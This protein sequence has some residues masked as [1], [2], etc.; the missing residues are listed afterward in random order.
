MVHVVIA[1]AP[2]DEALAEALAKPLEAAGYRVS[3]RGTV[4]VGESF[5]E[6]ASKA[7]SDGG[8]V[9][10]CATV[11]AIGTG[12]AHRLVHAAQVQ[13]SRKRIFPVRMEQ[14]AY[15][16]Q[17]AA[18]MAVAEYWRDA[19]GGIHSL[20]QALGKHYPLELEGAPPPAPESSRLFLDRITSL[21]TFDAEALE[22]F[23]A[24]LRD[25]VNRDFSADLHPQEFLRRAG[26][27]RGSH[28]T[29]TGVLLFGR[30]P[31]AVVPWAVSRC[32][33]YQGVS[34]T[35]D[36]ESVEIRGTVPEQIAALHR[37]IASRVRTR[38]RI[39]PDSPKAE[40][41]Y[42]YPMKTVREIIANALVHRDYEDQRR[43]VHVRLFTDQIEILSPGAWIGRDLPGNGNPV[44]LRDLVSESI[45]RNL[46]LAN[47]IS[48]AR[49]VEG[50]GSGLPTAIEECLEIS[51]PVP[52]VSKADGYVKVTILP[53]SDWGEPDL[54]RQTPASLHQ[55]PP[56]PA[57]FTGRNEELRE[58]RDKL[59][60]GETN[61]VA[62]QGLA[63][64]GKT[65]LAL[66]LAEELAPSFPDGQI[67]FNLRGLSS[68]PLPPSEAMAHVVR[69]FH[70]EA[71]L[72]SSDV[73][74]EALYRSVLH[75]RRTLLVFDDAGNAEQVE[76]L[77][78]PPGNV[79]LVTSR[80]QSSLM[81]TASEVLSVLPRMASR[82]ILLKLAPRIGD[83]AEE[84]AR[85]CGDLPLALNLAGSTLA[86]RPDLSVQE[87]IHRLSNLVQGE[88]FFKTPIKTSIET[89]IRLSEDLLKPELRSLWHRL[90]VFPAG[91]DRKAASAVWDLDSASAD[92]TLGEL[93][94]ASLI[95]GEEGR[96]HLHNLLRSFT[97]SRLERIERDTAEH[98]H[99]K[100][101]LEVLR[102][103][104][105]LYKQGGDALLQGL[106]L[107]DREWDNIQ[108]GHSWAVAH[109]DQDEEA[110]RWCSEYPQAGAYCLDL[111]RHPRERI[112][113]LESA[114]KAAL[115]L[116]DRSAEA[117]LSGSLGNAYMNLGE[118]R[119]ATDLYE[120]WSR[121]ARETGDPF[122]EGQ[123]LGNLGSAYLNLGDPLRAVELFE[124][125]LETTHKVGDLQG[126]GIALGNLASAYVT[127]GDLDRAVKLYDRRLE[128]A[129]KTGDLRGEGVTL[130][131]LANAYA[132]AGNL[133]SAGAFHRRSLALA[134]E[135]GDLRGQGI[136]LGNLGSVYR[137]LEEAE[138]AIE[139]LQQ[140]LEI[141]E[142]VGDRQGETAIS[143]ELGRVY[144]QE[145]RIE[146]AIPL[147]QARVDY[148]REV[149]HP[150]AE[151]H[152]EI[153]Q[154]IQLKAR[155]S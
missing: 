109:A 70:P 24:D 29:N 43:F 15:L 91:F 39:R 128:I 21:S 104:S 95:Y 154:R 1:H 77:R 102:T 125:W 59:T 122:G 124:R 129:R 92:E 62:L 152:A 78:P 155:T 51:A 121:I 18:D 17:I 114:L 81:G 41:T 74:L 50:E 107:F 23:R 44:S 82:E 64:V 61:V 42:E 79:V 37:A 4:L 73:E 76:S 131:N 112:D 9:V 69:S 150:D 97:S 119:Q 16:D 8:P 138:Q 20:L 141:L 133:E 118:I 48:W 34:K 19:S 60:S 134:R 148:E 12:W 146:Q 90:S 103:T 72:P 110:A 130:G 88:T 33:S 137:A 120:R 30:D 80:N 75:G 49:L 38:E 28:L 115:R 108:A 54:S 144:E 25:G 151:P 5:S 98:R 105:E 84:I 2:G 126:E 53:R 11:R 40:V 6:E 45:K 87:Y 93:L 139:L 132:A 83:A 136:A 89:S 96:Y 67:F 58:L 46:T 32:V 140:A 7:L 52:T 145:G 99:A 149:G 3:H 31:A 86:G 135:I 147:L 26:L 36:R 57:G 113:W 27:M 94:K 56:P 65:T 153:L 22:L 63:G 101:Y 35:A 106:A 66:K 123:A 85:L 117:L 71:K 47:I 68:N 100:Y 143:W 127:L 14:D 13:G 142:L 55:L 116:G 111:R 10:L